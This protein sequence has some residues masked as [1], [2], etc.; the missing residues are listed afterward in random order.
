M[1]FQFPLEWFATGW[2][3]GWGI[4]TT[5]SLLLDAFRRFRRVSAG[6]YDA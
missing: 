2:A 4:G 1:D 6:V 5:Y 3:I